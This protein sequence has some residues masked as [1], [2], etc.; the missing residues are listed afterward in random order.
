MSLTIYLFVF[1]P[2]LNSTNTTYTTKC[3]QVTYCTKYWKENQTKYTNKTNVQTRMAE[4]IINE[5]TN[6]WMTIQMNEW[7]NEYTK[8]WMNIQMNEWCE[9]LNKSD[10]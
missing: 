6:E 4:W 8:E 9:W 5:R 2:L 3:K 1:P 7:M 10:E